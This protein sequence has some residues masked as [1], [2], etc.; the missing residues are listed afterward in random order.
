MMNT[1]QQYTT[2]IQSELVDEGRPQWI[3][4]RQSAL[5]PVY[6]RVKLVP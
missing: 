1:V 5:Q 4:V 6:I 2:G 3:R